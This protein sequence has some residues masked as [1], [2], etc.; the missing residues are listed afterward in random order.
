MGY[1]KLISTKREWNNFLIKYQTLDRNISNFFFYQLEF[2]AILREYFSVIKLS[3]SIFEQTTGYSRPG[4]TG[5]VGPAK[6]GPT[7]ELGRLFIF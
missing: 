1:H 5:P 3:V 2:S 6:A 7:F 4:G